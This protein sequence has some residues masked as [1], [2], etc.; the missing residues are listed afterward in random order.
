MYNKAILMKAGRG[1]EMR[2]RPRRQRCH[3]RIAVDAPFPERARKVGRLHQH[4]RVRERAEFVSPIFR[5]EGDRVDG[6]IQTRVY[7]ARTATSARL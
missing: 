7:N 5:R 6:S 1:S 2:P 3:F 4:Y